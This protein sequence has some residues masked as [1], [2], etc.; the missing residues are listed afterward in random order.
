MHSCDVDFVEIEQLFC[1]IQ[2]YRISPKSS[3]GYRLCPKARGPAKGQGYNSWLPSCRA[4]IAAHFDTKI[5]I[6]ALLLMPLDPCTILI[7][8]TLLWPWLLVKVIKL[9]VSD[10][11]CCISHC[12]E[13][14]R[15]YLKFCHLQ[16]HKYEKK[17][18]KLTRV[19]FDPWRAFSLKVKLKN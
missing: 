8:I 2:Q 18:I 16:T 10:G 1:C 7:I 6:L 9:F 5:V 15:S 14:W 13:V 11:Q 19:N 3:K 12:G 17:L 4:W